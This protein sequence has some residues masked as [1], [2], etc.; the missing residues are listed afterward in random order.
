MPDEDTD[1]GG[2]L[3]LHFRKRCD[4]MQAKNSQLDS[5]HLVISYMY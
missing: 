1:F 3:V 5:M 4:H 2:S